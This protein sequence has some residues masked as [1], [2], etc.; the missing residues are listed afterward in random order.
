MF[1]KVWFSLL[2]ALSTSISLAQEI[3]VKGYFLEDSIKLG[4]PTPYI[5][6]ASYP[7]NTDIIFPD[8]LFNTRP[9]E[10]EDKWYAPTKTIEDTSYD[11]AIYYLTSFEIDSVQFF[12]MPVYQLVSGDS[13]TYSTA[14]DSIYFKHIVTEI[15]D[16]VTAEN[17][18]LKENTT[19]KRV[20]F[21]FNYPY[22]VIGA[23]IL[24]IIVVIIILV[25]GKS[26]KK[27]FVLRRLHKSHRQ[28]INYFESITDSNKNDKE[29][30]E[31]ILSTWKKYLEKLENRPYTKSTTKEI[32]TNYKFDQIE[33][34]LKGIDRVLYAADRKAELSH[35]FQELKS[36]SQQQYQSKVEEVKNG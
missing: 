20:N 28:F 27:S 31:A 7:A 8:S 12:K 11:S 3:Q 4:I 23:V 35:N 16:S 34:A 15:P 33:K 2:F 26:I 25:F 10:L 32:V 19:Y 17:I 30:A 29:K 6:T 21:A 1:R 9:Y 5:L 14:R 36:F 13:I 18:P 22:F 24:V